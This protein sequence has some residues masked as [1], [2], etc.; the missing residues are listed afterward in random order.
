[1]SVWSEDYMTK[2]L[3]WE[4]LAWDR[5]PRRSLTEER[6]FMGKDVA[7]AWLARRERWLADQAKVR[8]WKSS[9]KSSK[10]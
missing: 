3:K 4:K 9:N 10:R 8:K 1:V 7:S 6:E 2:K 5:K